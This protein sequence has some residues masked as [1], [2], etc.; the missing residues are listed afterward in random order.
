MKLAKLSLAAI[1]AAG[2]FSV[3]NATPLEDAIKGVDLSGMIRLRFYNEDR[4]NQNPNNDYNRWRSSEDF[5]FTIPVSDT[6]KLIYKLEVESSFRTNGSDITNQAS[7]GTVTNNEAYLNYASNGLN[8][9][10]GR[11]P[12]AT[13]V[14]TSGHGENIGSGVIATYGLGNGLTVA[15]AFVDDLEGSLYKIED[16]ANIAPASADT[17]KIPNGHDIAAL[18]LIYSNDMFDANA[19][20][21]RITNISKYVFT[22]G[23]TVKPM[24]GVKLHGDFASSKLE[25]DVSNYLYGHTADTKTFF[26]VNGSYAANGF[27]ILAGYAKTNK[28]DGVIS[29]NPDA[30]IDAVLPVAQRYHFTNS[31]DMAAYYAKAG[32]AVNGATNAYLAY[33]HVN[34][35][36]ATD[37]DSNEYQAGVKYKYNKK[38]GFHVYYSVLDYNSANNAKDNNEFRIEAKYSF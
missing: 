31:T 3:A 25:N 32:F 4:G 34:D 26:N 10:A 12:V 6:M 36:K 15:G 19:W 21:Y 27:S 17:T 37:E 23:A 35:K 13:T 20:Y 28:K 29:L 11:I 9:L 1:M 14:T 30:P 7:E 38:L 2:I 22:V 33:A 16:L 8:V 24:A 5:R 18:A